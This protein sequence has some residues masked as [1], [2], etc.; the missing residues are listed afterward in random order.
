MFKLTSHFP[1]YSL[2]GGTHLSSDL[3]VGRVNAFA[4]MKTHSMYIDWTRDE[5]LILE[6]LG[7]VF[8]L[9]S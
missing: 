2:V 8:D 6:V 9:S 5:T 7:I 4:F 3:R 1:C